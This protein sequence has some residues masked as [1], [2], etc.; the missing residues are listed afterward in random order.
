MN[1]GTIDLQCYTKCIFSLQVS[2][3]LYDN[4]H[5]INTVDQ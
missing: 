2:R 1:N 5:K 3:I 4:S